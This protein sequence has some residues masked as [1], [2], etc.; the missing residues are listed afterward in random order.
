MPR[1]KYLINLNAEEQQQLEELTHKGSVKARQV[2]QAMILLEADEGLTD[3]QIMAA[4]NV[5]RLCVER[6]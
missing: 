5:S 6:I 1:K 2:K 4:I 3:A